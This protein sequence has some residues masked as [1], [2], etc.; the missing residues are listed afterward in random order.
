MSKI[1]RQYTRQKRRIDRKA[2]LQQAK[3]E[4]AVMATQPQVVMT[5]QGPVE[6]IGYHGRKLTYS[7]TSAND[8]VR[9]KETPNATSIF[10]WSSMELRARLA[11]GGQRLLAARGAGGCTHSPKLPQRTNPR[12]QSAHASPSLSLSPSRPT[13]GDNPLVEERTVATAN[14]HLEQEPASL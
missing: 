9:R 4:R 7:T 6:Q 2:R 12:R 11:V 13:T 1:G 14:G 10:C 3:K 5:P 8:L